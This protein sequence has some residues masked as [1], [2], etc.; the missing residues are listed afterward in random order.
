MLLLYLWSEK[1]ML[2]NFNMEK[3]IRSKIVTAF[4]INAFSCSVVPE[5][6]CCDT[7]V[8]SLLQHSW[9]CGQY[10]SRITPLSMS[11]NVMSIDVILVYWQCVKFDEHNNKV[12]FLSLYCHSLQ[13]RWYIPQCHHAFSLQKHRLSF[14]PIT[15]QKHRSTFSLRLVFRKHV[16]MHG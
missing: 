11:C 10:T 9:L 4:D 16:D 15:F 2:Y 7:V 3:C 8:T 13:K 14:F 1:M 12:S 5:F 6:A